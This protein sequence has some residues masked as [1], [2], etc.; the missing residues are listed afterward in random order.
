VTE[1]TTT[2]VPEPK[3]P[4][5]VPSKSDRTG[6]VD[7]PSAPEPATDPSKI[8]V[9]G[10]EI[11]PNN[12]EVRTEMRRGRDRFR[13]MMAA[14]QK[15]RQDAQIQKLVDRLGLSDEQAEKLRAHFEKNRADLAS[16]TEGAE[17]WTKIKELTGKL[18]GDDLDEVLGEILSDE[19]KLAYEEMQQRDRQNQ[20]ESRALKDLAT[21]QGVLD[22]TAEQKDQVYEILH[23]DAATQIDTN[24]DANVL[25]S[26]FTEGMGINIDPGDLG[27]A[28][29][30][31]VQIDNAANGEQPSKNPAELMQVVQENRQREIDQ[32]VERLAPVLD[33]RQEESYR[34]HLESQGAGLL[35]GFLQGRLGGGGEA[36]QGGNAPQPIPGP[37][38][39][40]ATTLLSCPCLRNP[41][42]RDRGLRRRSFPAT[43]L[44]CFGSTVS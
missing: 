7:A 33:D 17:D 11:D 32:K 41:R 31:Q 40:V 21:I 9:N 26:S 44:P 2:T 4:A 28:S 29:I 25:V 38:G 22:L 10:Q 13:E 30:V 35:G 24:P 16:L 36:P 5:K 19:Q 15:S 12:A 37:G 6:S 8:V 39:C 27:I 14:R 42:S 43:R 1:D 20:I 18:R 23:E 3:T 34:N